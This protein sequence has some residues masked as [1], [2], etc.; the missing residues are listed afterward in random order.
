MLDNLLAMVAPH[1]CSGCKIRGTLLCANCKYDII[2]E[3]FLA[4]ISCGSGIASRRG[5]CDSCN[6]SYQR[7]WCVAD[8]R[9]H[10]QQLI[11]DYKFTNVQAAHRPLADLLHDHLPELPPETVIV[12]VPT[13]SSHVRQRGYDHMLLIAKRLG[14]LRTFDVH[15]KLVRRTNTKQRGAGAHERTTNAKAAFINRGQLDANVT[16][17]LIDDVV[18]TGAT[19]KYATQA[20]LDAGATTVW[21]ASISRQPLDK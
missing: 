13:V 6:V 16:Y 15:T 3:P 2:S 5:I 1:H 19:V 17:L 18:T 14:Q 9:D 10:L 12:P 8:R 7:A 21:V 11:D 4:C 20:L